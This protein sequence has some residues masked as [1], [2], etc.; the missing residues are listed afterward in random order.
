MAGLPLPIISEEEK[1][2]LMP[3]DARFPN[4][5]V[6]SA[7]EVPKGLCRRARE[8]LNIKNDQLVDKATKCAHRY[9]WNRNRLNI[10]P[11]HATGE[12]TL[13]PQ[14]FV[15]LVEFL[16]EFNMEWAKDFSLNEWR[17]ANRGKV[18]IS[19]LEQ[20]EK[21]QKVLPIVDPTMIVDFIF[22]THHS[23]LIDISTT[24]EKFPNF[25]DFPFGVQYIVGVLY[26]RICTL[27]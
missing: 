6:V 8:A 18:A 7:P 27:K 22:Q 21:L 25:K 16:E 13:S 19:T 9:F 5:F 11:A 24:P 17:K 1:Y 26:V 23:K 15:N 2:F 3:T 4:N 10:P 20:F 14:F 12:P